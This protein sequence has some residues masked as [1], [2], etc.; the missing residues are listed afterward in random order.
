MN[1]CLNSWKQTT[2]MSHMTSTLLPKLLCQGMVTL[3]LQ[4]EWLLGLEMRQENSL[5]GAILIPCWIIQ[6]MR[7]SLK[8][9]LLKD[10]MLTS[11]LNTSMSRLMVRV[12]PRLS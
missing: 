11:L 8:M 5:G 2:W 4:A 7:S 9:E 12:S 6:S 1:P 3:L 10:T